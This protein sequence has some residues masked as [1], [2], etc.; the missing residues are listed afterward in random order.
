PCSF[1]LA[2]NY[3]LCGRHRQAEALFERLL[4]LRNDVGLLSEEYDLHNRRAL[5]NMP[6]AL[7]HVALVNSARNLSQHGGPSEHRSRGAADE[8]PPGGAAPAAPPKV[9]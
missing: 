7:T 4:E 8:P 9:D 5:G 1:W 6:Q 3:A 2:D